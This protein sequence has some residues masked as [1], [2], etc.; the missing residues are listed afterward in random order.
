MAFSGTMVCYTETQMYLLLVGSTDT[1][2]AVVTEAFL[3]G[4]P[5]WKHL[6]LEDITEEEPDDDDVLGMQQTFMVMVACQCAK[7]EC[8]QGFSI[9]ITCPSTDLV[10]AVCGEI[11]EDIITVYLGNTGAKGDFDYVLKTRGKSVGETTE[12]LS[13]I[14]QLAA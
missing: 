14:A 7:D 11:Q 4:H 10:D 5:D 13:S 6:A 3:K 12:A 2:R 1:A 8:E 9:L